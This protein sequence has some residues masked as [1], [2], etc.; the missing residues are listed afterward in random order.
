MHHINDK[1]KQKHSDSVSL[2]DFFFMYVVVIAYVW[3]VYYLQAVRSRLKLDESAHD[4]F[5]SSLF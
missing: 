1:E 5:S 2:L 4:S 3:N